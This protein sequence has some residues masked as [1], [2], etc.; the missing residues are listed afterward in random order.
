MYHDRQ[1]FYK[2]VTA[3][4]ALLILQNQT[5]KYSSPIIFNDPFDVQTNLDYGFT[6]EKM[7]EAFIDELFRLIHDE[8]EPVG[9]NTYPLVSGIQQMRHVVKKSSRRMPKDVFRQQNKALVKDTVQ[10]AE[11][12]LKDMNSLWKK[13][14]RASKV[15]CVAEEY[16]NLLMWAH[17]ARDHTGAVIKFECLRELDTPLCIAR[18]VSYVVTPP[19]NSKSR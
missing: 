14:A 8:V 12:M 4:T 1:Y 3:E 13:I 9:D 11:P 19:R 6:T 5:L 17:Y 16:D 15:F 7:M 10:R 18:K 2:Y